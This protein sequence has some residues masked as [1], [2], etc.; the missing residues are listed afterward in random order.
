MNSKARESYIL[1]IADRLWRRMP[2]DTFPAED[3]TEAQRWLVNVEMEELPTEC[4]ELKHESTNLLE[5]SPRR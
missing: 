3:V 2:V 1:R 5:R 4:S